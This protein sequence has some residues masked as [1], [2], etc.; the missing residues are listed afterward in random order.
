MFGGALGE[1]FEGGLGGS[2]SKG[3]GEGVGGEV[4]P[5]KAG[6]RGY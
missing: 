1:G 3:C 4:A 5:L 2:F 6:V